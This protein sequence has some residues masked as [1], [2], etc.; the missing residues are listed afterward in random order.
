[1]RVTENNGSYGTTVSS[2]GVDGGG[3]NPPVTDYL[4]DRVVLSFR[5]GGRQG[6]L[7]VSRPT[8]WGEWRW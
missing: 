1:M 8:Y 6:S 7:W 4:E 2:V 5:V 3:N